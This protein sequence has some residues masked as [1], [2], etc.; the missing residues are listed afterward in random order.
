VSSAEAQ[1]HLQGP[2]EDFPEGK[3]AI[4]NYISTQNLPLALSRRIIAH[5]AHRGIRASST[6]PLAVSEPVTSSPQKLQ[7]SQ[8]EKSQEDAPK[9]DEA[10]ITPVGD[11]WPRPYFLQDGLRRVAP[12]HFTYNTYC[13]ERWRGREVLDVF[14]TE[15]RD[16]PPE[17][18]VRPQLPSPNMQVNELTVRSTEGSYTKRLS[19]HK[20]RPHSLSHHASSQRRRNNAHSAPARTTRDRPIHRH[21]P[22]RRRPTRHKQTRGHPSPSNRPLQLQ[23]RNRDPAFGTQLWL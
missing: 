10:L 5:L 3:V 20:R 9:H 19:P 23:L 15:F 22:R 13:K 7:V 18:Y 17:Y 4:S 11:P 1:L 16:R 14:I 2:R 6:M 8:Q 21:N 12:Y